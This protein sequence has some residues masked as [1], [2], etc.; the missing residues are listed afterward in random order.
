[1]VDNSSHQAKNH[2]L[3]KTTG[4]Y[5]FFVGG[6]DL[7]CFFPPNHTIWFHFYGKQK[8][9]EKKGNTVPQSFGPSMEIRPHG[10]TSNPGA[11]K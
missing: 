5:N 4:V 3:W 1:M 7:I 11:S 9:A 2:G 8:F 10:K 6:G